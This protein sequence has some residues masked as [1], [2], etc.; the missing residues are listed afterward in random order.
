ME[1]KAEEYRISY[2]TST[3]T[4]SCQGAFRLNGTEEYAPIVQLLN[5]AVDQEPTTLTL[6]LRELEFLNS[7]GISVLSKFVIRVRRKQNIHMVI[8]GSIE[9][10]WQEKSLKNLQR[11]MPSMQLEFR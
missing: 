9:I 7:S 1:I 6:N 4:I 8:Q 5:D 2:N 3:T 11:M 10:P